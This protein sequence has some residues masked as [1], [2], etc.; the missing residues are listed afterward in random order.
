MKYDYSN[1]SN[2]YA[3]PFLGNGSI[4]LPLGPNGAMNL[5][6][7]KTIINYLSTS[8]I[9]WAGR[10][11]HNPDTKPVIPFGRFTD[12]GNPITSEQ[13]LD[14][15]RAEI[16]CKTN[17]ENGRIYTGAFIHTELNLIAVKKIL[18]PVREME[19]TFTYFFCGREGNEE[20]PR[21]T[22]HIIQSDKNI[23][24]IKYEI[25]DRLETEETFGS[26]RVACSDENAVAIEGENSIS[27]TIKAEARKEVCFY[28]L[29][30][31]NTDCE[32]PTDF[33]AE[34]MAGVLKDGYDNIKIAHGKVWSEY[35]AEGNAEIGDE[36]IDKVYATAQYHQKCF[37]TKW[38]LPVA[39]YN[40]AWDARYF[41]FD[42]HY[43]QMGLLTSNHMNAAR[44]VP[45][46]RKKGLQIAIN[47][48]ECGAR[49]PWETIEDGTEASPFGSWRDH[50]FHMS[51]IPLSGWYYYKYTLDV[52]FLRETVFPV[53]SACV[54]FFSENMLYRIEG[55]KLIVG[56]CTDLER[57][58]AAKENAYM[59]T[60]GVIDVFRVYSQAAHVLGI[61]A[62]V[63]ARYSKLA[64]ELFDGLPK[65]DVRYI[66]FPGC[67]QRSIGAFSGTF[68]F[69]V[70]PRDSTL[71]KN[72]MDDY[73]AHED[74]FGNMYETGK[75]V[76][77]WYS[78][79]KAVAFDRLGQGER[80]LEAISYVAGT[81]GDFYEVYEINNKESNTYWHPWFTTAAGM[82]IHAIN[83]A[84]V[85]S[86]G[87]IVHLFNGLS[88]DFLKKGTNIKFRLAAYGDIVIECEIREAKIVALRAVGGKRCEKK[89]LFVTLPE[90]LGGNRRL[91]IE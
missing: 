46:F 51:A 34:T 56:K 38:S 59:T 17:Y 78:C 65:E 36:Q 82:Y 29:F 68:P 9:C 53:L 8:N 79:W 47:R 55:G 57:L 22:K 4:T 49:Y 62:D 7:N 28:I 43:M 10:R 39:L 74:V 16:F 87:D 66:P 1:P 14:V 21:F 60:C 12:S 19:Y 15:A 6:E 75:G 32:N 23:G 67:K 42:E 70:I 25:I 73:L 11:Y 76:C 83:E 30:A 3:A 89:E 13:E 52:E 2:V 80:A 20:A 45:E 90:I 26:I 24:E 61:K 77:S 69:D 50:I 85:C 27:F 48:S 37:T 31:D 35:Y 33:T 63:A 64:D 54:Y 71:Q 58:G 41:G 40:M 5:L 86:E 88:D 44:R 81:A 18:E 84:L 72:A 91:M